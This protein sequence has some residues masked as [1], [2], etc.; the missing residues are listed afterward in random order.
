MERDEE[1]WRGIRRGRVGWRGMERME[2]D[3]DGR[4]MEMDGDEWRFF[5]SN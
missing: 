3:L 5:C 1:V 2:R 4:W